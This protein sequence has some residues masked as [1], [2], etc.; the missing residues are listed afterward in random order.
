M[1]DGGE[2]VLHQLAGRGAPAGRWLLLHGRGRELAHGRLRHQ[3]AGRHLPTASRCLSGEMGEHG[4]DR[5][6]EQQG[7]EIASHRGHCAPLCASLPG[8]VLQYAV[9][10]PRPVP[11]QAPPMHRVPRRCRPPAQVEL[12]RQLSQIAGGLVLDPFPGSLLHLPHG[13]HPG[14]EGC[15]EEVPERYRGA[16]V[17]EG[18]DIPRMGSPGCLWVQQSTHVPVPV[19]M[20][21]GHLLLCVGVPQLLHG[22]WVVPQLCPLG[23]CCSLAPSCELW[24]LP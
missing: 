7:L 20:S 1:A 14:A 3:A 22:S 11:P 24:A 8:W 21:S 5:V 2:R 13:D 9:G 15:H 19:P 12:Q 16:V 17:A 18:G 4:V 10:P 23:Y 6:G